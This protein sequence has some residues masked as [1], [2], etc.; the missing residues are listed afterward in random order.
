MIEV[1]IVVIIL[2]V[3]AGIVMGQFIGVTV[4]AERTAFVQSGRL[5]VDAFQRYH[6]DYGTY[7]N[8]APG[9]LPPG[10][11]YYIMSQRWES[12]TPVG[13]RWAC[14]V[15][16]FGVESTLGVFYG[17]G[18]IADP[19]NDDAYMQEID[20]IVDD[21]DLQTGSFRKMGN[22]RYYFVVRY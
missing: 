11:G 16:A 8:A 21:G 19:R 14:H 17:G 3:L 10:L 6:L 9:T 15:N 2:G 5:F 18:D 12:T 13:G 22:N 7:P 1:L 20:L 4:D